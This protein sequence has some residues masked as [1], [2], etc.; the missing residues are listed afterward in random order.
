VTGALAYGVPFNL[1]LA[2]AGQSALLTFEVT[3]EAK[4][5]PALYISNF[6][7]N[8]T[9]STYE[10]T[11]YSN[12]SGAGGEY[13]Q[14]T[15][16]LVLTSVAQTVNFPKLSAGTYIVLIT[17]T[18]SAVASMQLTLAPTATAVVPSN[19]TPVSVS[20]T[21]PAEDAYLSFQGTAGK[22]LALLITNLVFTPPT[23]AG[24][25]VRAYSPNAVQVGYN[26]NC[27]TSSPSCEVLMPVL[28][29]SGTYSVAMT[30][31]NALMTFNASL[32]PVV[33]ATIPLNTPKN[34]SLPVSGQIAAL[35]FNATA[36]QNITVSITS[37]STTPS[38]NSINASVYNSS[39]QVVGPL[40]VTGSAAS[41]ITIHLTALPAGTYTILVSPQALTTE[42]LT[43]TLTSP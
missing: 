30:P 6:S 16:A 37:I 38:G 19:G 2:S 13:A 22:S 21:E 40:V 18:S 10:L 34:E 3:S 1:A 14:V 9:T 15:S 7:N 33:T 31:P 20:T 42:T 28:P 8:P 26:N 12:V 27:V 17:P 35:S 43:V 32:P 23:T 39:A 5:T 4:Q 36:G 29:V 25:S 24:L 11:V 41:P